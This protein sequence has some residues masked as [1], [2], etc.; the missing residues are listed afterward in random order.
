MAASRPDGSGTLGTLE[1]G[2]FIA[3]FLV[4]ATH[5][6]ATMPLYARHPDRSVFAAIAPPGA[7]AVQFFFVLSG[8]VMAVAHGGDRGRGWQVA[9]RFLWRRA[10]R[11]YPMYWLALALAI[12]ALGMPHGWH[13]A[14]LVTLWPSGTVEDVPPAWTLRYEIGFYLALSLVLLPRVGPGVGLAWVVGTAVNCFVPFECRLHGWATPRLVSALSAPAAGTVFSG[15]NFLFYAGLAAGALHRRRAAPAP[16]AMVLTGGGAL[17]VCACLP[18]LRWG[19]DFGQTPFL[20]P[21]VGAAFGAAL[22]GLAGLERA[23]ILRTGSGALRLGALSYPLYILHAVVVLLASV[24]L[25]GV[26]LAGAE[27]WALATALVLAIGA[28]SGGAAFGIDQ[29]LQRWLRRIVTPP[30]RPTAFDR[31]EEE[32]G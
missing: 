12:T 3:A 26:R 32:R 7:L 13:A 6:F 10:C 31:L 11:I 21:I 30:G 24:P 19:H 1:I 15:V 29:P 20:P 25:G 8:F 22:L 9:P 28:A 4:A 14:A 2:R 23:R 5:V 16:A 18:W 17:T 27:L